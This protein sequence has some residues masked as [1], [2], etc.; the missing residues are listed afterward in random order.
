MQAHD[1]DPN[2]EYVKT[3]V[4]ELRPLDDPRIIFQPWKMTSEKKLQLKLAGTEL[5]EQP[6][7]KIEFHVAMNAGRGRGRSGGKGGSAGG[8]RGGGG[9]QGR[10]RGEKSR[11]QGRKGKM[12]R[13][14]DF[15]EGSTISF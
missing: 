10:G 1:Y 15:V 14:N 11:G 4:A 6:L 8:S 12:E 9:F 2:G 13:A 7:K 3:W 5:V